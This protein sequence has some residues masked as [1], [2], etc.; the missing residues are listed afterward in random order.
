MSKTILRQVYEI[1]SGGYK[2]A[3]ENDI[4]LGKKPIHLGRRVIEDDY[5]LEDD[6]TFLVLNNNQNITITL[7]EKENYPGREVSISD[8]NGVLLGAPVTLVTEGD[9]KINGEN[10][11]LLDTTYI[12]KT[13]NSNGDNWFI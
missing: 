11:F 7:P 10:S 5:T 8:E 1:V 13:L 12:F 6:A 3:D 2:V 9:S 4:I